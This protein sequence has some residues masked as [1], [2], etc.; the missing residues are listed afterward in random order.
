MNTLVDQFL[1][2]ILMERG[3]SENTREAYMGDI[4]GFWAFL[5]KNKIKSLNSV[6]RKHILEY[7]SSEKNR[8]LSVN[9]LARRLVTIKVFF[10]YL[11]QEGILARNITGAMDSPRLW[12]ILPG[13]LSMKEVD[14]LLEAPVGNDRISLRDKAAEG[15][16]M[17]NTLGS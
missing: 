7:L 8:G 14:R 13:V 15:S 2:Y 10:R 1:D 4:Q 9:S 6:E 16:S 11:A 3:L 12:K 17:M 5:E